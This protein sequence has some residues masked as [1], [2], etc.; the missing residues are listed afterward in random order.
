VGLVIAQDASKEAVRVRGSES[1]CHNVT[2][3]AVE[4][5]PNRGECNVVVSGGVSDSGIP[6]LLDGTAEIAMVS[7]RPDP[8]VFAEAKAKGIEL[9]EAVIGW[10]GI[11]AVTHPS[12]PVESLTVEQLRKILSGEFT[13]WKQVGGPDKPIQVIS[14]A[15]GTR[16]GTFKYVTDEILKGA[17]FAPATKVLPYIRLVPPAVAE[18]ESAIGLLRIRNLERLVE[19]GM[20]KKIKVP[21]IKK[22]D[23]SPAIVP[24]RET[25]DEGLYPLTRPYLLYIAANKASKCALDFFKFC[26]ARNPR[27]RDHKK[28]AVK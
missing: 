19:Q 2:V 6:N 20:D 17:G 4:F 16:S 24:S 1:M 13:S 12:N 22:D 7:A 27:P 9:K 14:F 8:A 10:G 25:V 21:G 3:Y 23:R 5:S 26:E 18:N 28:T 11:V 15:E